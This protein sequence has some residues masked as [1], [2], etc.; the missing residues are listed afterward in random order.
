[1]DGGSSKAA[2]ICDAALLI[3]WGPSLFICY[4]RFYGVE[5]SY[6]STVA[7]LYFQTKRNGMEELDN[8]M[9]VARDFWDL[10]GPT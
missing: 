2:P 1:V 4:S 8:I 6:Y 9:I 7:V 3:L 5:Q 10:S